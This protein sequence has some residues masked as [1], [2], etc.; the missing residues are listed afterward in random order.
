MPRNVSFLW[1]DLTSGKQLR[2]IERK[3]SYYAFSTDFHF[4]AAGDGS[5]FW[6]TD[7]KTGNDAVVPVSES[8]DRKLPSL[9]FSRNGRHLTRHDENLLLIDSSTGAISKSW[10]GLDGNHDFVPDTNRLVH[11]QK[12]DSLVRI[13][14][15]DANELAKSF[16]PITYVIGMDGAMR[17]LLAAVDAPTAHLDLFDLRLGRKLFRIPCALDHCTVA[18]FAE[19]GRLLALWAQPAIAKETTVE[20]WSIPDG[21]KVSSLKVSNKHS[22]GFLSPDGSKFVLKTQKFL[23]EACDFRMIDVA[24]GKLLWQRDFH[25]TPATARFTPDSGALLVCRLPRGA[26]GF[27]DCVT[28]ELEELPTPNLSTTFSFFVAPAPHSTPH[29]L[30]F[31]HVEVKRAF[32]IPLLN[33]EFSLGVADELVVVDADKRRVQLTLPL[34]KI[35]DCGVSEHGPTLVTWHQEGGEWYL[36]AWDLPPAWPWLRI[37]G[38]PAGLWLAVAGLKWAVR[39]RQIARKQLGSPASK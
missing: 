37:V 17:F 34:E 14:D 13:W 5:R 24:T 27:L 2:T 30:L 19:N 23:S 21:Q 28:G 38:V 35:A 8:P 11:F 29:T 25:F 1:W 22:D 9:Q 4:L 16:G 20:F 12:D 36:A 3:F 18:A 26:I 10:D 31:R 7:T 32:R 39:R 6:I 33:L 15:A